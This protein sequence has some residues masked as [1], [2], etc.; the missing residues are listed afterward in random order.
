[1]RIAYIVP[2]LVKQ[3]PVIVV[4]ELV[5]QLLNRGCD[6]TVFYFDER[7][8]NLLE[9]PCKTKRIVFI[10]TIRFQDF[11]IVHTHGL[12]PDAYV[13]FHKPRHIATR[14]V[15]TIHNFVIKDF[16]TQYNKLIAVIFGNLWMLMLRRHDMRVVLSKSAYAYYQSW[17]KKDQLIYI[18][19]TRS[20]DSNIGLTDREEKELLDFKGK[21]PFIGVNAM[22][23]PIKGIDQI[24]RSMPFIETL[25]LWIVG[26]GKSLNDLMQ[27]ARQEGVSDRVHFAGYREDAYRYIPYYDVYMM[28]SR[29]EG[30]PLALL[31]AVALRKKVV[32]SD[33]PVFREIFTPEEVTFFELENIDSLVEAIRE[34]LVTD[35]AEAAYRRYMTEYAPEK[36]ADNYLNLY[37]KLRKSL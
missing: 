25:R 5:K 15:S 17:F 24:L 2:S 14:F 8:N 9:F 37:K 16:T 20:V 36:F 19:N 27:L 31:E 6:V 35:K 34:A 10:Q 29:S 7:E 11:D 12:R 33:I 4:F 18:Y 21:C 30:F 3:G 1:M 32:C 22:L 26:K 23:T 13:F 28:P